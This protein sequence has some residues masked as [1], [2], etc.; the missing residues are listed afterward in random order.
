MCA[1][2]KATA[3]AAATAT[4][5]LCSQQIPSPQPRPSYLANSPRGRDYCDRCQAGMDSGEFRAVGFRYETSQHR[6][7]ILINE[8]KSMSFLTILRKHGYTPPPKSLE[9]AFAEPEKP[10]KYPARYKI[11]PAEAVAAVLATAEQPATTEPI[12]TPASPA[13]DFDPWEAAN[14]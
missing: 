2:P 5:E 1:P 8:S 3:P 10:R 6:H 4:C 14:Y 13:A 7:G 11:T 12:T 9:S